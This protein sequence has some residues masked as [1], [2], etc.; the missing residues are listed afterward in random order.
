MGSAESCPV[1]AVPVA[2]QIKSVCQAT[3]GDKD[4]ADETQM[5]F[6]QRCPLAA[7]ITS[8][9]QALQGDYEGAKVTQLIFLEKLPETVT[10]TATMA[11]VPLAQGT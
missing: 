4:G 5:H 11:S 10:V 2:S 6:V 1:D 7:Q 9:V 8:A 3:H